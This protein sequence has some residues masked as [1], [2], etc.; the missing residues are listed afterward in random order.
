[1]TQRNKTVLAL[2][3]TCRALRRVCLP[4]LQQPIEARAGMEGVDV[5]IATHV[6]QLESVVS[7]VTW[8]C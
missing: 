8:V 6:R 5:L 3:M 2:A 1:M 7:A 4:Y